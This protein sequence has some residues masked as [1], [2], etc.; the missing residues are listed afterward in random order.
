MAAL[1][2]YLIAGLLVWAPLVAT[3]VVIGVLVDLMDQTL[4]LLPASLR[5]EAVLG[6][7]VPGLGVLLSLAVL[8]GTG[9]LVANFL[10]R[11]LVS[12][13]ESVLARI[14]LVRP[15]YSGVKQILETLFS[16]GGH[17]F[18]KVLMV[19]YPYRGCW[20][21]AF[22][23]GI[24]VGEAQAKTGAEVISVFLPMTPLPTAGFFLM[25]PREDVVELDMSVDDGL[26]MLLSMGVVVPPWKGGAKTEFSRP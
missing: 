24:T 12:M 8:I 3:F 11:R 7:H 25:I 17:S 6:V 22:Q 14:P 4:L 2:R 5:P 1:R 13:G 15:I 10:G 16:S 9:A 18:R 26:K 19:Q 21:L 23:T 20:T